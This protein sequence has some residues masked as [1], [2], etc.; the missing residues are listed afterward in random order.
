[1]V[2]GRRKLNAWPRTISKR[3]KR[4]ISKPK[5]V[6]LQQEEVPWFEAGRLCCIG[7]AWVGPVL[8]LPIS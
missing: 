6:P 4:T 8:D 5:E 1:M 2:C 7:R 3:D